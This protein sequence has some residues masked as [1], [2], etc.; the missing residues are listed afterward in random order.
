MA[1]KYESKEV[2]QSSFNRLRAKAEN[3]VCFDCNSKNPTWSSVPF[4]VFLCMDCAA[5]HR[6]LGVHISFVRSTVLD[7]WTPE[8]LKLMEAGGNSKAKTFFKQHGFSESDAEKTED[9]YTS[10]VAQLYKQHLK[11]AA[12]ALA[13]GSAQAALGGNSTSPNLAP[14]TSAIDKD[15]FVG[16]G[17]ADGADKPSNPRAS[18]TNAPVPE[19]RLAPTIPTVIQSTPSSNAPTSTIAVRQPSKKKAGLGAKRGGPTADEIDHMMT[20]LNDTSV[21]AAAM[22]V[23]SPEKADAASSSRLQGAYEDSMRLGDAQNRLGDWAQQAGAKTAAST[24]GAATKAAMT[25]PNAQQEATI[26]RQKFGDQKA[27]SSKQFFADEHE[28]SYEKQRKLAQF[29]GATSISSDAY[30]D[31]QDSS[32]GGGSGSMNDYGMDISASDLAKKL[33][34]SA[35]AEVGQLGSSLRESTKKFSTMASSFLN[36]LQE[37]Y[38]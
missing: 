20:Q 16:F 11:Q 6:N 2:V 29:S 38:N 15:G 19:M 13:A 4:G 3:K 14:A 28:D 33:A 32:S 10:R 25:R 31:R 5:T 26:A 27:I 1:D 23:P 9:K 17:D 22:N 37:R 35:K 21:S 24:K 8:Q 34:Y 18:P 36:D 12:V 30:F 7:Q